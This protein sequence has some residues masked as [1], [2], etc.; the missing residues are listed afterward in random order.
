MRFFIK[1]NKKRKKVFYIYG[2]HRHTQV[3][4]NTVIK[5]LT[6]IYR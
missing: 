2:T 3:Q 5:T 6:Q 1:N 4:A